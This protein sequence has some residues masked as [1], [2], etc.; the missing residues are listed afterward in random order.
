[1]TDDA[2]VIDSR[3]LQYGDHYDDFWV[4][5][6]KLTRQQK[7]QI[8]ERTGKW[9]LW[10]ADDE[11]VKVWRVIC[12]LTQNGMLGVQAKVTYCG[13]DLSRSLKDRLICVYTKD[14]DDLADLQRVV[15]QLRESLDRKHRLVYKE[16]RMILAGGYKDTTAR[17]VSKWYVNPYETEIRMV[18]GY[19]PPQTG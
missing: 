18:K 8:S 11:V 4:W 2:I 16:D 14:S 6:T 1:M 9:M 19:V 3:L 10:P 13:Y 7:S 5:A 17:P 12:E 15:N